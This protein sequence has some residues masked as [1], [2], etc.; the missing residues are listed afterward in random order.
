MQH[1]YQTR[2]SDPVPIDPVPVPD[3]IPT[4]QP[5]PDPPSP[6]PRPIDDPPA[7][8]LSRQKKAL[9]GEGFRLI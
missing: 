9:R 2:M 1:L 5:V 8:A 6:D 7:Y 3:P 4:P